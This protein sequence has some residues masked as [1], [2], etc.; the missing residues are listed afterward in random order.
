MKHHEFYRRYKVS[1]PAI[2]NPAFSKKN[3][4]I[5]GILIVITV[6]I[7]P[8]VMYKRQRLAPFTMDY[9][10]QQIE[11]FLCVFVPFFLFLV[12]SHRR[13]SLNRKKGYR[14]V[15]K[16]QITRKRSSLLSHYLVLTPGEKNNLKVNFRLY[17]KVHVGDFILV[18]RDSLGRIYEI[19]ITNNLSKRLIRSHW[20]AKPDDP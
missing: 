5:V 8:L 6:L 14:W 18:R 2:A 10:V 1:Y 4:W 16:F 3:W 7:E 17:D 15:G 12:W 19:S 13:E 11:Y 9:Y 20:Q